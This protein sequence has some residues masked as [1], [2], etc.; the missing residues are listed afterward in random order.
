VGDLKAWYG[1]VR[2]IN[3]ASLTV[4]RGEVVALLGRNGA[5]KSTLLR[6]VSRVHQSASGSV[7]LDGA[8]LMRLRPDEVIRQGMTLVR[9]GGRVFDTLTVREHLLLGK[10]V[11]G[12]RDRRREIE[13]IQD[14]FPAVWALLTEKA[15][16]LSGGERQM[17]ILAMAFLA[18]P[19]CLLL[20][21]PSAGLA[22]SICEDVYRIIAQIASRDVALL[23]AEQDSRWVAGLATRAYVIELGV[24]KA[25]V[26]LDNADVAALSRIAGE[27]G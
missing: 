18:E 10:R 25:E 8:Q 5:G 11:A 15:G 12:L 13:E 19:R 1:Q 22:E 16:H 14:W 7:T 21:E 9:E 2:A 24:V 23:V 20:D 27:D 6:A 3:D 26:D 17:L 4:G